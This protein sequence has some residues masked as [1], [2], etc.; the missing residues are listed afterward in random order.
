MN[1]LKR[2]SNIIF[3]LGLLLPLSVAAQEKKLSL[4]EAIT[5]ALENNRTIKVSAL[6]VERAE[7]Q[8]RI[9][10][11]RV[12]PSVNLT[13]QYAH[14]FKLPVFFG[15]GPS[16]NSEELPYSR[17]GGE[18]QFAAAVTLVQPLYLPSQRAEMQRAKLSKN[19]SEL[20]LK[21]QES[22]LIASV[23]QT[24]LGILVLKERLALQRESLRRN[25]KVLD[26]ARSLYIQGRALR[27]DTLRAYTTVKN[28]EPDI[29]R[30]SD[31]IRVGKLQLVTLLGLDKDEDIQFTDSLFIQ[32]VSDIPTEEEVY[33]QAKASRPDL[34]ALTVEQRIAHQQSSLA[35]AG[36][37]PTL[38]LV[39]Q[40]Q[41]ASQVNDFNV[42]NARWPS[43]A[44]A[45]LQLNVPLF[46]GNA[47]TLRVKQSRLAEQ[48][49][50]LQLQDAQEQ[51][52][53]EVRQ[54]VSGLHESSERL[55][56]QSIVKSTAEQ[57]YQIIQYR[58]EKGVASR[59]ELTDAE[60]ALTT[61]DSNY[62]EAV[63]DYLSAHIQLDRVIGKTESK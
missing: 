56:T 14:Y 10:R 28:L 12:L 41:L 5:I 62:L 42:D 52:K 34:Q 35:K 16:S 31:A 19:R 51:L 33:E 24:Y 37:L 27:V 38:S 29:L 26:D 44:F 39:G 55:N 32:S 50:S 43:V 18:D 30:I 57:S 61:A 23:K 58:Y 59:L 22:E 47:N 17:I 46:Q 49:S 21:H 54:V 1:Y 36:K 2:V 20:D 63:F 4:Q 11:S 48:Q 45:G 3:Y 9:S 53:V 25:Q 8:T 60:L 40:Y 7:Y 13:G 15:F 6:D